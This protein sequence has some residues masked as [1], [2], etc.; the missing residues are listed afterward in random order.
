MLFL[1]AVIAL[2]VQMRQSAATT[3]KR[4]LR[5]RIISDEAVSGRLNAPLYSRP[6]LCSIMLLIGLTNNHQTNALCPGSENT[7]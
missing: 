7:N 5:L 6:T 1:Y 3:M 2:I 4:R